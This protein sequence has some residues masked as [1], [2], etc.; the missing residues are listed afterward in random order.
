MNTFD[1]IGDNP[2]KFVSD[3][4]Q[5][6]ATYETKTQNLM[7]SIK[8][9]SETSLKLKSCSFIVAEFDSILNA[10]QKVVDDLAL[11]SYSNLKAWVVQLNAS[12]GTVLLARLSQAV[13]LWLESFQKSTKSVNGGLIHNSKHEIVIRDRAMTLEPPVEHSRMRLTESLENWLSICCGRSQIVGER[14]EISVNSSSATVMNFQYLTARLSDELLP[15]CYGAIETQINEVREYSLVWSKYQSLWD[16]DIAGVEAL[17]GDSL[18]RWELVVEEIRRSRSTFD[19][20]ET[21]RR[22]GPIVVEFEHAQTKVSTKYDIWQK[23]LMLAFANKLNG[24][25]KSVRQEVNQSRTALERTP[26][27][28]G[29][30]KADAVRLITLIEK[31]KAKKNEWSLLF[32]HFQS[33]EKVLQRMRFQFPADWLYFEGVAGEWS[34]FDFMFHMKNQS[35]QS[36]LSV[37]LDKIVSEDR[38]LSQRIQDLLVE[39]DQIKPVKGGLDSQKTIT[40]LSSFEDKMK[41]IKAEVDNIIEAKRVFSLDVSNDSRLDVALEELLDLKTVWNSLSN[42]WTSFD[43]LKSTPWAALSPKK[44]RQSLDALMTDLKEM[45]IKLRQYA[46]HEFACD[47]IK[48]CIRMNATIVDLKGDAIQ[49]RHWSSIFKNVGSTVFYSTSRLTLG[50]VYSLNLEKNEKP[51]REVIIAAQGEMALDIFLKQVRG[52]W[53]SFTLELVNYGNKCR[54]IKGI[55]GSLNET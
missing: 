27:V 38:A 21:M 5:S 43:E 2:S 34:A 35:V 29:A 45:P 33:G 23:D 42:V 36:Q 12:I 13:T 39:W 14:F 15:S 9:L 17:L 16:L 18:E 1:F 54:L 6:V 40:L 51:I 8:L 30:S 53:E 52:H 48:G 49:D 37:L 50:S 32:A 4:A 55:L 41:N 22:F 28:E 25:M 46:A 11:E 26:P 20:S 47:T 19:T 7:S 44:V 3:L 31:L 24:T 10:V